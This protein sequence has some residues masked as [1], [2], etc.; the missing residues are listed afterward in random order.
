MFVTETRVH[1]QSCTVAT[2]E[3]EDDN[4]AAILQRTRQKGSEQ[5]GTTSQPV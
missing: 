2:R 4:I 3:Q 5:E 1:R